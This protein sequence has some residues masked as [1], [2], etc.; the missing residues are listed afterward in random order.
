[1]LKWVDAGCLL[2]IYINGWKSAPAKSVQL[3]E[4]LDLGCVLSPYSAFFGGMRRTRVD[5]DRAHH[6]CVWLG[7]ATPRRQGYLRH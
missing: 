3:F 2:T 7:C 5:R 6:L 1:M 4:Q